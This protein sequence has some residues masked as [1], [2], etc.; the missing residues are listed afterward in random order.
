MRSIF[1]HQ[2]YRLEVAR[3]LMRLPVGADTQKVIR[4]MQPIER[5][6]LRGLV[7]W[8]EDYDGKRQTT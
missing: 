8:V 5:E 4:E 6:R 3:K 2:A 7:D 1:V